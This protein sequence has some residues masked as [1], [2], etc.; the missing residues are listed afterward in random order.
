M[1]YIDMLVFTYILMY[2][3]KYV[4]MCVLC[5]CVCNTCVYMYLCIYVKSAYMYCTREDT[6]Y[7]PLL[8]CFK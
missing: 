8:W 4:C 6:Y 7:T 1:L 2:V 5:M 3:C